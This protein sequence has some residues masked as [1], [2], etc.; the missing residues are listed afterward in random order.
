MSDERGETVDPS[1]AIDDDR[2][3]GAEAAEGASGDESHADEPAAGENN[4]DASGSADADADGSTVDETAA[5]ETDRDDS[6]G[7]DTDDDDTDGDGTTGDETGGDETGGDETDGDGGASDETGDED[8]D[9]TVESAD[10]VY[11]AERAGL[12]DVEKIVPLDELEAYVIENDSERVATDL[13]SLR[14]EVRERGEVVD[15]VEEERE[16]LEEERDDLES[17]LKRTQAEFQNY[18]RRQERRREEV[19]ARATE[20]L[21]ERLLEVRDNLGRALEQ[22]DDADIREGV[23]ATFRQ[24]DEVLRGEDVE[25]VEPDPGDDADPERHEVLLRVDSD[26]PEGT[27]DEV[28]RPGYEMA[29]KVLRPAQVTVSDG[30]GDHEDGPDEGDDIGTADE[31]TDEIETDGERTTEGATG[32]DGTGEDEDTAGGRA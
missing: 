22:D 5:D 4:A 14:E 32:D 13:A 23:E 28:H 31:E 12:P 2:A 29:G 6:Q 30:N 7:D 17:R 10:E 25:P 1:T 15:E 9:A 21:V 11:A 8:D 26:Q 20:S 19:R 24:L 18:K 3:A 27:V 16:V